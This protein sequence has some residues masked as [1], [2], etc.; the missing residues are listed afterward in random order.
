EFAA[1]PRVRV[2]RQEKNQGKGAA[3]RRAI[4]ECTGDIAIVQDA[5]LEYAPREIPRVIAPILEGKADAV[6]GSRFAASPQ[7][8]VLLFWHSVGNRVL[9][10]LTNILND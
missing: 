5:D 6:F 10:F 8:K 3:I 2:F 7:R 9:T 1:D 4:R